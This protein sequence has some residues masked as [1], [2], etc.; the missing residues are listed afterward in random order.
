[1]DPDGEDDTVT[2]THTASGGDYQGLRRDETLTVVDNNVGP[3]FNPT[4]YSFDLPENLD[5]SSS[6]VNVG[7]PV[8]ASDSD[9]DD[10]VSYSITGGNTDDRFAIHSTSGQITYVGSGEDFESST[11]IYTLPV[12]ATGGTG[13]R[14]QSATAAVTVAITDVDD[15]PPTVTSTTF[16]TDGNAGY[17]KEGNTI[18]VTFQTSEELS[19]TPSATIAGRTAA[20][21]GSDKSWTAAYTVEAGV[22]ADNAAFDLGVITDAADNTAD[23]PA[24]HTGIVVDTT[25]PTVS[26]AGTACPDHRGLHRLL[27]FQRKRDRFRFRR[28]RCRQRHTRHSRRQRQHLHRHGYAGGSGRRNYLSESRRGTGPSRQRWPHLH[29][30]SVEYSDTGDGGVRFRNLPSV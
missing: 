23:P 20:V 11:S 27:Y 2:I 26:I 30:D 4:S 29:G 9:S 1:M 3:V 17:A 12:T 24:V 5:G 18:T 13:D 28:H 8:S 15:T 7:T 19:A 21:A 22:N 16:A 14:A 25:A 6:P 10:S